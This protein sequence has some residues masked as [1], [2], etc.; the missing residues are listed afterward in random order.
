MSM[1]EDHRELSSKVDAEIR[2]MKTKGVFGKEVI[3]E[4][5]IS[6][7]VRRRT[8]DPKVLLWLIAY[9][10]DKN[11]R[12]IAWSLLKELIRQTYALRDDGEYLVL[13]WLQE[14]VSLAEDTSFSDEAWDLRNDIKRKTKH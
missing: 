13:R 6:A 5:D 1:E 12:R 10:R 11:R 4:E 9:D 8:D 3:T 7:L 2:R 14:V